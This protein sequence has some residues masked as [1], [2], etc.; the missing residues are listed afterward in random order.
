[1]TT[2]INCPMLQSLNVLFLQYKPPLPSLPAEYYCVDIF[3]VRSK[4]MHFSNMKPVIKLCKYRITAK[5][6]HFKCFMRGVKEAL[7][8][9]L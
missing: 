4:V 6:K 8:N 3:V 9:V 2:I 5:S 7:F 1:M